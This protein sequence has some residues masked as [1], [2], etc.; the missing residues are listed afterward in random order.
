MAMATLKVKW[1]GDRLIFYG[2]RSGRRYEYIPAR[3][4]GVVIVDAVDVPG[5][6][7]MTMAV[8]T[9]C[10]GCGAGQVGQAEA[11]RTKMFEV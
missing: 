1:L 11:M 3:D 7:E 6:R 4:N 2:P 8:N 10:I 5:L 9:G